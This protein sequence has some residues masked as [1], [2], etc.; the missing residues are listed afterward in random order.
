MYAMNLPQLYVKTEP[1]KS[2]LSKPTENLKLHGSTD[3][4]ADTDALNMIKS[5]SKQHFTLVH[6]SAVRVHELCIPSDFRLLDEQT[7]NNWDN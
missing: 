5:R 7:S 4:H 1:L 2:H 3:I 6:V